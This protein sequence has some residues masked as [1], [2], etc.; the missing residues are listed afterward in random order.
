MSPSLANCASFVS[1][2]PSFSFTSFTSSISSPSLNPAPSTL[3]PIYFLAFSTPVAPVLP[4]STCAPLPK[5]FL[6]TVVSAARIA[7][8]LLEIPRFRHTRSVHVLRA[9]RTELFAS[10]VSLHALRRSFHAPLAAAHQPRHSVD[11][12]CREPSYRILSPS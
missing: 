5:L 10:P 6:C 12:L 2:A 9:L 7:Y 11:R 8:S 4:A 1:S 3:Y